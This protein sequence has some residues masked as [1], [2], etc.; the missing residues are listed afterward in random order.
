MRL[1]AIS[2][3][4]LAL[5]A[6]P[7]FAE[8]G[9][10]VGGIGV[11]VESSPGGFRAPY[12][13]MKSAEDACRAAGGRFSNTAGKLV[14]SNPKRDLVPGLAVA[15]TSSNVKSPPT[16]AADGIV[17]T[18]KESGQSISYNSAKSNT[19]GS[20]ATAAEEA[21]PGRK[22]QGIAIGRA[23]GSFSTVQETPPPSTTPPK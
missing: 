16:V 20:S 4:M 15:T 12:H 21:K 6:A 11:S 7:A 19:A 22:G 3:S 23:G 2:L 17:E 5:T 10:P 1:I 13:D 18:G 8:E 14:C 9:N